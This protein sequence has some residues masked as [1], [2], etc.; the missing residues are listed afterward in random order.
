MIKSRFD[1]T[2]SMTCKLSAICNQCW[3][4]FLPQAE[5]LK[6]RR[7]QRVK[8]WSYFMDQMCEKSSEVDR[9]YEEG[10]EKAVNYYKD[11]EDKLLAAPGNVPH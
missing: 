10:R 2:I 1:L 11:V 9:Q 8:D 6:E 7:A 4:F 5:W 3:E